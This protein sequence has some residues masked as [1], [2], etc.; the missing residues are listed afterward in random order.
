[1]ADLEEIKDV[2]VRAQSQIHAINFAIYS[3]KNT[4]VSIVELSKKAAEF[5][6]Q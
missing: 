3:I 6:S 2:N 4:G 5:S 1:V